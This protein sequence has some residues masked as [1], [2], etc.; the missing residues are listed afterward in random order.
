[1]PNDDNDNAQITP[2]EQPTPDTD[3]AVSWLIAW[4]QTGPWSVIELDPTDDSAV[5]IARQFATQQAI[6]AHI[7][8]KNGTKNLYFLPNRTSPGIQTTPTKA[9]ITHVTS[10]YADLDLPKTGPFSTPTQENFARLLTKLRALTP[11]PTVII[12]SGGGY[13]AFWL[14]PE[15]L[16]ATPQTVE[17]VE[18]T[19][20]AIGQA[21]RSDAVQNINRLMRLPGTINIP[22]RSKLARGRTKSLARVIEVDWTRR[23]SL[24]DDPPPC[25]ADDAPAYIDHTPHTTQTDPATHTSTRGLPDVPTKYQKMI[26]TG[27]AA[28]YDGDRSKM[29][30]A[31][32]AALVRRGWADDEILPFLIDERYGSS[33]HCLANHDSTTFARR[34][35]ARI[36]TRVAEGWDL[37]QHGRLDPASPKNVRIALNELGARM[38]FNSFQQRIY[39]NGYGPLREW[40]DHVES[41]LR[42]AIYDKHQFTP[43]HDTLQDVGVTLARAS[44]HHP[45][46]DYLNPLTH[47]GIPRIDEWLIRY[48]GA[49]DT[50]YT[51]AVSRLILIAA[52]RRVRHPGCKFD[53]MLVLVNPK[54]GTG[55]SSTIKALAVNDLW[56]TDSLPLR[57][58]EQKVIEQLSG[59]WLVECAELQGIHQADVETLDAFLSRDTD[60][61]RLAYGRNPVNAPRQCV[62]FGTT[63]SET[64]LR[65]REN[66]RF[67]PLRVQ[68]MDVPGIVA[69]RDQLWAEAAHR[70]AQNETITLDPA[71]WEVAAEIQQH[72][73]HGDP[74]TDTLGKHLKDYTGR[75]TSVDTWTIVGKPAHQRGSA[76][77]GRMTEVMAELG[78]SRHVVRVAGGPPARGF[79]KGQPPHRD[80]YV[81][82]DPV[83]QV[84][85]VS[86]QPIRTN[87]DDSEHQS[88]FDAP[89]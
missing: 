86:N 14:F 11:Q 24:N 43:Q 63:N 87:L 68:R 83:T 46:L 27:D 5:P 52:V 56:F 73:R 49:E 53:Q 71:L 19:S 40:S 12:F 13:Q 60:R 62:F 7:T 75:I 84:V 21:L 54:Q 17:Y 38:S 34:Q 41:E 48:G 81:F 36:R 61:A 45:V 18:A 29:I 58:P 30:A 4:D 67:W 16:P 59:K 78:W 39:V 50:A 6:H 88:R 82:R 77:N 69:A 44:S 28:D 65:R 25:F 42:V 70:E 64:F 72:A 26:R 76:D 31:I 3:A 33:A 8:T 10:L 47:D 89:F 79:V 37:N 80:I 85:E 1:M 57:A 22:N 15:S 32:I 66:R 74:W 9:Q 20:K 23:F 55:K 35:I 2:E 51:R